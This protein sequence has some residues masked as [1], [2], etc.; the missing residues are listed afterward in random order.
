LQSRIY[1]PPSA[2][3]VGTDWDS[4]KRQQDAIAAFAKRAGFVIVEEF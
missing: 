3:N 1:E 2:A 4:D